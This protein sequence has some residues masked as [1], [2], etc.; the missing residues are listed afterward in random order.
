MCVCE[1]EAETL[2]GFYSN[3]ISPQYFTAAYLYSSCSRTDSHRCCLA[4]MQAAEP[5][6]HT[7]MF[8]SL[9]EI[10]F[11]LRPRFFF[12]WSPHFKYLRV[13]PLL[14]T[15]AQVFFGWLSDWRDVNRSVNRWMLALAEKHFLHFKT[16]HQ[17]TVLE[18][19][20]DSTAQKKKKNSWF[21]DFNNIKQRLINSFTQWTYI[22]ICYF[23]HTWLCFWNFKEY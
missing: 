8:V 3:I 5:L 15:A 4:V 22:R 19:H 10:S 1:C 16:I 2:I 12:F 7:E 14:K 11:F 20:G 17:K 21:I 23:M 9:F 18:L 6:E 13:L